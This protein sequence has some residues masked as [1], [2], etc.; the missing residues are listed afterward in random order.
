[1]I[2]TQEDFPD[3]ID[4]FL[5]SVPHTGTRF[6]K[7]IINPD[8]EM[9]T[10]LAES[11]VMLRPLLEIS[12][13]IVVSLR[14]PWKVWDSFCR[15]KRTKD[16]YFGCWQGLDELDKD[17]K[18]H[19]FPIDLPDRQG[20]LDRLSAVLGRTVTTDWEPVGVDYS[21]RGT[22]V[23]QDLSSIYELSMIKDRY[24]YMSD[25]LKNTH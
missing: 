23:N 16:R 7:G 3:G 2:P 11:M 4:V 22:V 18:L 15:M 25:W 20:N 5:L 13:V 12:R 17:F 9:H 1:M 24:S 14:D 8:C 19:Y 21:R 10:D 6:T